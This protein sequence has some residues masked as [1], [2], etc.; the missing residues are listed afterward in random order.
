[1]KKNGDEYFINHHRKNEMR[2]IGGFFFDHFNSGDSEKDF[3]MVVD[4][5]NQFIRSYFPILEKRITESYTEDDVEFQLHRRGRYVEFN[6]LHDRGTLF[7]LK[8]NGRVDSI[9][10]SLP[11]RCKF[12][13]AYSPLKGSVHEQM[14]EYYYPRNW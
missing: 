8:T 4:F 11:A 12:S 7:G 3:D 13:Y 6:L 1:M 2:G 5:S 10:I 14:M 9:L